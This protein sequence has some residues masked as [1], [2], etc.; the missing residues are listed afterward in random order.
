MGTFGPAYV[1]KLDGER[2]KD[3]LERVRSLMSDER[4]RTLAEIAFDTGDP[5]ASISAQLR[6]LRK[7]RFGAFIVERRR[8]AR[9][10]DQKKGTHEYRVLPPRPY[11]EHE[12]MCER[13]GGSGKVKA[14][15][16]EPSEK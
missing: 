16:Y 13:C 11:A 7:E 14:R 2:I 12:K 15:V 9:A 10:G 1:D 3:Q 6:H 5:Q 4:W 8:R